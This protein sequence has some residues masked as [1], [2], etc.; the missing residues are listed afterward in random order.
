[1]SMRRSTSSSRSAMPSIFVHM[2]PVIPSRVRS[3]YAEFI[4]AEAVMRMRVFIGSLLLGAIA[5]GCAAPQGE[6][7][8][9]H[10]APLAS[11]EL[12]SLAG[13]AAT[14]AG[15]REKVF[16]LEAREVTVDLGMGLKFNAWTY[17]GQLPGPTLEV[18]EGDRIRISVT[19]HAD[20]S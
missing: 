9:P 20:T 18:C 11:P 13:Q 2:T 3:R 7:N 1:M 15:P 4:R 16:A 8:S 10:P 12:P 17:N 14:C 6:T 5:I 19:N